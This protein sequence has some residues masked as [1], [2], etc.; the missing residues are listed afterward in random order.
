MVTMV[1]GD[2]GRVDSGLRCSTVCLNCL[3]D[4]AW[5]DDNLAGLAGHLGNMVEHPNQSQPNPGIGPVGTPSIICCHFSPLKSQS[6][7]V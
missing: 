6:K 2:M 1:F 3:P 4:F 5:V 7:A